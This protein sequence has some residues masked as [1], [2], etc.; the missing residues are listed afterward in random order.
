MGG[1]IAQ[2]LALA[3]PGLVRVA[4]PRRHLV[5]SDRLLQ[6]IVKGIAYTAGTADDAR[7][8]LYSFLGLVYSRRRARGRAHRR[9]RG[10]ALKNPHPQETEAFQRTARAILTTTPPTGSTHAAPTLVVVGEDDLLCPPRHSRAIA[11]ASSARACGDAGAGPP[12]VPGGSGGV[13]R[14]RPRLPAGPALTDERRAHRDGRRGAG[15]RGC[16]GRLAGR[17]RPC[18][19]RRARPGAPRRTAATTEGDARRGGGDRLRSASG[20]RGCPLS[21]SGAFRGPHPRAACPACRWA[22]TDLTTGHRTDV[23]PPAAAARCGCRAGAT[24]SSSPSSSPPTRRSCAASPCGGT[25]S[26]GSDESCR[27]RADRRRRRHGGRPVRA[28]PARRAIGG[29]AHLHG[30]PGFVRS[31]PACGP[32]AFGQ[33]VPVPATPGVFSDALGRVVLDF[34]RA[35]RVRPADRRTAGRGGRHPPAPAASTCTAAASRIHA[36]TRCRRAS[37]TDGR[38]R[39]RCRGERRQGRAAARARGTAPPHTSWCAPEDG[40]GRPARGR[41]ARC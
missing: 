1:A 6:E 22:G 5:P 36:A 18:D 21:K 24:R 27:R 35:G 2:E 13:Q 28:V 14:P 30:P 19:L 15:R 7:A 33:R 17:L 20:W 37:T 4:G 26:A 41:S 9:V 32:V 29:D 23:T 12:A 3:R 25:P 31:V 16:G 34:G 39:H 11:S 40:Q 10:A 8:W 38:A